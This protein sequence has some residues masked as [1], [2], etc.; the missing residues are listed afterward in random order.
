M[1]T[2]PT[3]E[4]LKKLGELQ[5]QA[6]RD[7]K[8]IRELYEEN[9]QKKIEMPVSFN[10]EAMEFF[11][12]ELSRIE[13]SLQSVNDALDTERQ[14]RE[15]SE[16]E[17]AEQIAEEAKRFKVNTVLEILTLFVGTVAAI[18]GVLMLFQ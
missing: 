14:A 5:K 16:R 2:Y 15:Q 10:A 6:N 13:T 9:I 3:S 11:S 12:N 8:S 7:A 1:R 4:D 17:R 18:A